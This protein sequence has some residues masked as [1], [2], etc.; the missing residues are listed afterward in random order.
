MGK[1][2]LTASDNHPL[3]T[4]DVRWLGGPQPHNAGRDRN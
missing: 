2:V 1:L 4:D 3:E